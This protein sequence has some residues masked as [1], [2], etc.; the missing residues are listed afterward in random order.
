MF[1]LVQITPQTGTGD[2]FLPLVWRG[3]TSVLMFLPLSLATL[4]SLP[5]QD[6][7]AGSGFY[8]LT[9]QLGGSIGIAVLTTLLAQ[10]EAFHKAILVT[11]LN[12]V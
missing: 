1:Q 9:R 10:R 6:I 12:P 3:A 5:K 4:G 2:L 8:K 7:S 11:K